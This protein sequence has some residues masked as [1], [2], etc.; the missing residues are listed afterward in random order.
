MIKFQT[1]WYADFYSLGITVH[2]D[3]LIASSLQIKNCT[4]NLDSYDYKLCHFLSILH[5]EHK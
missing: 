3:V 1:E 4:K 2:R 5:N